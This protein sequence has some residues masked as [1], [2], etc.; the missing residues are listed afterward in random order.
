MGDNIVVAITTIKIGAKTVVLINPALNP[1]LATIKATSPLD[2]MP[3]PTCRDSLFVYLNNLHPSPQPIIFDITAT[4]VRTRANNNTTT[5]ILGRTTFKPIL[6]KNMGAK[7][8]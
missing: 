4:M 5:L 6:A 3:I 1:L 7:N 8:A 2:T